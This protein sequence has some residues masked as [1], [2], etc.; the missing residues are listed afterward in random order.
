[1]SQNDLRRCTA[2]GMVHSLA[3]FKGDSARCT[4]CEFRQIPERKP[5]QKH[6]SGIQLYPD[7]EPDKHGW[8]SRQWLARYHY[9]VNNE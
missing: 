2:C 7:V 9:E 3:F 1:M 4:S 8:P 6:D 5:A